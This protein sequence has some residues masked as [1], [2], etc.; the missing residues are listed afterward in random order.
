M[1]LMIRCPLFCFPNA[2][3]VLL[4]PWHAHFLNPQLQ[5]EAVRKAPRVVVQRRKMSFHK[6]PEGF[7]FQLI[8]APHSATDQWSAGQVCVY[9]CD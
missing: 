5:R 8:G 3:V 9:L 6:G 4:L 2:S 7:G 1:T